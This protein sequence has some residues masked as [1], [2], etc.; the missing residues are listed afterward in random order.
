M[1]YH[2]VSLGPDLIP[3]R[4]LV[5]NK[6]YNNNQEQRRSVIG[7]VGTLNG[8]YNGSSSTYTNVTAGPE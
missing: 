8:N 7:F 6:R 3:L 5:G 1:V 4:Q 2:G